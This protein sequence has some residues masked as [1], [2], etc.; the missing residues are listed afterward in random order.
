VPKGGVFA[1]ATDLS[2]DG[3]DGLCGGK[4]QFHLPPCSTPVAQASMH[5][6][7]NSRHW[8]MNSCPRVV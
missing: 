2:I 5:K 3:N 7:S 6:V 1:N 8:F 4:I